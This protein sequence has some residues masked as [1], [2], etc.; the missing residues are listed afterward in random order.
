[1]MRSAPKARRPERRPLDR[2]VLCA[3]IALFAVLCACDVR[4]S[5][6][7]PISECMQYAS[8]AQACLGERLATRLL[9][10]VLRQWS[11]GSPRKRCLLLRLP[12]AWLGSAKRLTWPSA[13]VR[14]VARFP[15]RRSVGLLTDR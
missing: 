4:R 11:R 2:R 9:S 3:G 12:R 8:Q 1:M 14:E 6:T 13:G 7:E 10:G 15:A 5:D